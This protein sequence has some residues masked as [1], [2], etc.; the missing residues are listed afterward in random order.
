MGRRQWH[1]N[2]NK[3]YSLHKVMAM[4]TVTVAAVEHTVVAAGI[5]NAG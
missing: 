4:N 3:G 5:V 1:G 2:K